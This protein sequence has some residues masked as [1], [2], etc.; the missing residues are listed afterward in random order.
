MDQFQSIIAYAA[1]DRRDPT[2]LRHAAWFARAARS[3][4]V[5]LAHIVPSF[6]PRETLPRA[7]SGQPID[8]EV[9]AQLQRMPAEQEGLFPPG[10]R[11]EC[12]AREGSYLPELVRLAAQKSADLVCVGR[13]R[14]DDDDP[15]GD[16]AA[17]LVRKSPCS[18]LVVPEG[19]E[20]GPKRILVPIDF[21]EPSREALETGLSVAAETPGAAITILNVYGVPIGYSRAGLTYEQMGA[22]MREL[23]EQQWA[24]IQPTIDF[25][26]VPWTVRYELGDYVAPTIQAVAQEIDAQLIVMGSHGRTRPAAALLGHVADSVCSKSTRPFLAVKRK[27]EVVNLLRALLQIYDLG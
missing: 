1:L 20:P 18:A 22:R 24:E 13:L 17:N 7:E 15:I 5:Y 14:P 8:E 19:S 23:A 10:T 6:D 25:R 3:E 21:S 9:V 16:Q 2:T 12:L 4:V 11:V 26:G 27:G